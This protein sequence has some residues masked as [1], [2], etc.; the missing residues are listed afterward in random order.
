[1]LYNP[2]KIKSLVI[3]SCL[4][5]S[6]SG[7]PVYPSLE[8]SPENHVYYR[9]TRV[10]ILLYHGYSPY[11]Q[12]S[13][14]LGF[15]PQKRL[16]LWRA[17]DH[18]GKLDSR[19]IPLPARA[20]LVDAGTIDKYGQPVIAGLTYQQTGFLVGL[21][22][23]GHALWQYPSSRVEGIANY[24]F[25]SLLFSNNQQTWQP[26]SRDSEVDV[27]P[28]TDND[29]LENHQHRLF[30]AGAKDGHGML[31]VMDFDNN[32]PGQALM[33]SPGPTGIHWA[34]SYLQVIAFTETEVIALYHSKNARPPFRLDKWSMVHNQ[35]QYQSS[36]CPSCVEDSL[37]ECAT[38]PAR[39]AALKEKAPGKPFF[40]IVAG[41]GCLAFSL[42]DGVAGELLDTLSLNTELHWNS[43]TVIDTPTI[44][45]G[46]TAISAKGQGSKTKNK[47]TL[48]KISADL[49][50]IP[51]L[52]IMNRGKPGRHQRTEYPQLSPC[53]LFVQIA[54][55]H[56]V[57]SRQLWLEHALW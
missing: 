14:S 6:L 8:D 15:D 56:S 47:E 54:K 43:T 7:S 23:S 41:K 12:S 48:K 35:W 25:Y 46:S 3:T 1:M 30:V 55:K 21:D 2:P 39:M 29:R 32:H 24:R 18:N 17:T 9:S 20:Y 44:L 40:F 34:G 10:E 16:L 28:G 27:T 38:E 53:C 37:K 31:L 49:S 45:S 13:V 50:V 22:L 42:V 51:R 57:K 36:F 52:V 19:M 5:V 33:L 11:R 4:C 26:S